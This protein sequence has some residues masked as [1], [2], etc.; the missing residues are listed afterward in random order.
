MYP[1][2]EIFNLAHNVFDNYINDREKSLTRLEKDIA[3]LKLECAEIERRTEL[4]N[5]FAKQFFEERKKI[6]T[7]AMKSLDIAIAK[8]DS[9]I[10]A[11]ALTMIGKEYSKDFLGMMNKIS[12]LR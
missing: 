10:S 9:D 4:M 12:G 5:Q 2:T 8:G 1:N 6:R 11:I 7:L 3:K